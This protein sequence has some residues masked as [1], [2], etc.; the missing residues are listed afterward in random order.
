MRRGIMILVYI[1]IRDEQ[2]KKASLEALSEARRQA[3]A[4]EEVGAVVIGSSAEGIRASLQ[5]YGADKIYWVDQPLLQNY[6]SSGYTEVLAQ[7]VQNL[8]PQAVFIAATAL[9]RD[10]APRLAARLGV[11]LASDCIQVSRE[12]GAFLAVRP[13]FAGKA[14]LTVRLPHQPALITLRPNVF[15][16]EKVAQPQAEEVS[17]EISLTEDMIKEKVVELVKGEQEELDVTEADIVI[18]GGRGLKGP[19]NFEL[20]RRLSTLL[21]NSAIGASRSAVD[22]GWIDHQHQVGQTGKTVSPTLYMAFGISGAIQHLAGMSSSKYIV[23][24]NKDP[25]APIFKVADFGIVGDLF[26]VVPH[27]EEE[28]KKYK[29][30]T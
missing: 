18:S 14:W 22:A 20:L 13:I 15:P 29:S 1:E 5:E 27:L 6:T 8:A 9:G 23:A 25:E 16:L 21:P 26:E 3:Q 17:P 24:V 7:L 28:L 10:L 30:Q 12:A 19:E 11:G 2:I 4:D